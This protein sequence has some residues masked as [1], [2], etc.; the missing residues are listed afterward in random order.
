MRAGTPEHTKPA[1]GHKRMQRGHPP[2]LFSSNLS[3]ISWTQRLGPPTRQGGRPLVPSAS[4]AG[5][6]AIPT[7]ASYTIQKDET[8]WDVA[9]QHGVS[10]R[11]IKDLN[12]LTGKE[13]TLIEGQQL[14]VPASGITA[15]ASQDGAMTAATLG[16]SP[17]RG[18]WGKRLGR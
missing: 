8:L 13:P 7:I 15:V 10:M 1:G 3:H 16:S 14:L 9:V 6:D 2:R 4:A 18:I 12:K 5:K 11:T 17:A